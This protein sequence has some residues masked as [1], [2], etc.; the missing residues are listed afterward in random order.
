MHGLADS[1]S[2]LGGGGVCARSVRQPSTLQLRNN[3]ISFRP[4]ASDWPAAARSAVYLGPSDDKSSTKD[5][6]DSAVRKRS[7]ITWTGLGLP[8]RAVNRKR[9]PTIATFDEFGY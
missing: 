2:E 3:K 7:D 4:H 1:D 5:R 9:E 6:A 8:F